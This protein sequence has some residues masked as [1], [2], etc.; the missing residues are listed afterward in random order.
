MRQAI[1][2][3]KAALEPEYQLPEKEIYDSLWHYYYDVDK[4]V[5]Y[6]QSGNSQSSLEAKM[7]LI[8]M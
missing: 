3:V 6:L 1:V 8:V 5:A 2:D 7:R 4:S